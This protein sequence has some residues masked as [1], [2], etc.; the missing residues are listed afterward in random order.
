MTGQSPLSPAQA[1]RLNIAPTGIPYWW[2]AAPLSNDD[3]GALPSVADVVVIGAGWTGLSAALTLAR[4]GRSVLVLE[5]NAPG[6][7]GSTR[8]GGFF[9][10]EL[11][12][13]LSTLIA[14]YGKSVA[15]DLARSAQ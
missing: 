8:N 10:S 11:R 15:L 7:G 5:A 9:G 3:S 13:S 1:G 4:E 6:S 2:K 12:A 14:R